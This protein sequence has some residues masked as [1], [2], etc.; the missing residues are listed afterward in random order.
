M[1][2]AFG[3]LMAMSFGRPVDR[4]AVDLGTFGPAALRSE[5]TAGK[6]LTRQ[7]LV[8][9]PPAIP[10]N[11]LCLHAEASAAVGS[12]FLRQGWHGHATDVRRPTT[13]VP[14]M[15]VSRGAVWLLGHQAGMLLPPRDVSVLKL[16]DAPPWPLDTSDPTPA[17]M[18]QVR[19]LAPPIEGPKQLLDTLLGRGTASAVLLEPAG[20]SEQLLD[21][22]FETCAEAYR[23]VLHALPRQPHVIW[24][25]DDFTAM[26]DCASAERLLPRWRAWLREFANRD[27]LV[28]LKGDTHCLPLLSDLVRAGVHI[29]SLAGIAAHPV[30]TLRKILPA[31]VILHGTVDFATLSSALNR[32]RAQDL[33]GIAADLARA[34]PVIASPQA[35]L[36]ARLPLTEI[37]W[38][39]DYL[40]TLGLGDAQARREIIAE[41]APHPSR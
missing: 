2:T 40:K 36:P 12:D 8:C 38:C 18:P 15:R 29:V 25:E 30:S 22:A 7:A 32:G 9:R 27:V 13:A 10:A 1:D 31:H 23:R 21:W 19:S 24:L 14:S 11:T 35:P 5:S 33:L 16:P 17:R 41:Q 37:R 39:A 26:A 3:R 6:S 28:G 20:L 4:V 34:W